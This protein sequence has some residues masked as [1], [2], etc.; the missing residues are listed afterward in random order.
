MSIYSHPRYTAA[1]CGTQTVK[2][3]RGSTLFSSVTT[4]FSTNGYKR[5]Q[6]IP[7]QEKSKASDLVLRTFCSLLN[8]PIG[9]MGRSMHLYG[10]TE[11]SSIMYR[12]TSSAT[13]RSA[14]CDR[15]LR[16]IRGQGELLQYFILMENVNIS[17]VPK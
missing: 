8:K 11:H 5:K 16:P 2:L 4:D 15:L 1:S 10:N 13:G 12:D 9:S 3:R 14:S 17:P 6:Q 7:L